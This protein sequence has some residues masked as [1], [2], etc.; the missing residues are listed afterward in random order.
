LLVR[1]QEEGGPSVEP[2]LR[3]GF[4]TKLIRQIVT[5]DLR[6]RCVLEFRP[7][8]LACMIEAPAAEV[9]VRNDAC[10]GGGR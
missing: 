8:G 6:G 9:L 5:Y 3:Q 1:W 4:G 2:P 10:C 7:E